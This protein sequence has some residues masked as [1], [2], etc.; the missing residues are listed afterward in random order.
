MA[1]VDAQRTWHHGGAVVTIVAMGRS[2][3]VELGGEIDLSNAQHLDASV[4]GAVQPDIDELVVDLTTTSY[5]DS[6]GLSLLVR[7]AERLRAARIAMITVAPANS[8]AR[9]VITLTGL[10]SILGLQS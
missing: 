3:R 2:V 6:A 1:E 4:A 5:L 9:R 8:A 7:L 10:G